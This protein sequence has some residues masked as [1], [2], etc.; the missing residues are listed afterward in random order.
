MIASF[1]NVCQNY[2]NHLPANTVRSVGQ[3]AL[4]SFSACFLFVTLPQGNQAGQMSNLLRPIV[5][6][7]IAAL[8]SSIHAL[9]NP[10]F[11]FIF[12]DPQIKAYREGIKW[13]VVSTLTSIVIA[14]L[15][16]TQF[17]L[18]AIQLILP[19]SLNFI[20]GFWSSIPD[21]FELFDP[22]A[23]GIRERFESIGLLPTAGSNSIYLMFNHMVI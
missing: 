14:R 3:S 17:D 13:V 12:G 5:V 9:M 7:G 20:R 8:A 22:D 15:T 4:F 10:L 19:L 23:F 1:N 11:E 2:Y 18:R 6:A 21:S 16:N